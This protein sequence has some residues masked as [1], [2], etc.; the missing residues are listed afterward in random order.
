V[1]KINQHAKYQGQR[2]IFALLDLL[3]KYNQIVICQHVQAKSLS[4]HTDTHALTHILPT[5]ISGPL[6]W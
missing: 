1:T 6:R 3:T 4:S 2:S 5:V